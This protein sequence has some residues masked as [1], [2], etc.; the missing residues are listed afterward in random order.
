[1]LID[2]GKG[3]GHKAAVDNENMLKVHSVSQTVEHHVNEEHGN[4]YHCV[5]S[6]SPPAADD[7][8]FYMINN[9][10][11]HDLVVEGVCLGFKNADG[12]DP[13]IY[14]EISNTGTR[15]N[16]TALTPTNCNAGSGQAADGTFEKG[17]DLDGGAATL[18]GG[19]VIERYLFA[20]V[21][22]QN[23]TLFNFEQDIILPKNK[24]LTIWAND[25][26]A[27]YYVTVILNF[28]MPK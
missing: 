15:N 22:N 10:D 1:M 12:D 8:I 25:A 7:C 14:L 13:E 4:A 24:T 5:F 11:D 27:T 17:A 28:H 18:T 9:S 23:S 26:Q 19:T 16:A 20:N 2:D 6:Q 3:T 21:Q